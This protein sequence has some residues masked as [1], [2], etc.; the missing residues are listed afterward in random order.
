MLQLL[1]QVSDYSYTTDAA[2]TG[3]SSVSL[4]VF[5][6]LY[7]PLIIIMV[8]SYWKI[9]T[10]AGRPGWVALIPLYREWVVI[11]M[12]GKP[13]WWFLMLF[14]PIVNIVFAIMMYNEL[15]KTFGKG[16]GFVVLMIFL[17]FIAFPILGFGKSRYTAPA[18]AAGTG[19]AGVTPP[20]PPT[21]PTSPV[22][23]VP[24]TTPTE[25]ASQ[26]QA[27]VPQD[28]ASSPAAPVSLAAPAA[29]V[30]ST[31]PVS[32]VSQQSPTQ[33]PAGQPPLVQ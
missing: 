13:A 3:S 25:S 22:A 33:P 29:P 28:L 9:F 19:S 20:T 32:P 12:I 2:T 7:L 17:P 27:M 10:K 6:L 14:I 31:P 18:G 26:V 5:F 30:A 16:A 21:P 23:P 11:E 15:A 8:A 24:P 4:A 1:A